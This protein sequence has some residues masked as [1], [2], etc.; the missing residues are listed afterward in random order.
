NEA[1]ES[2]ARTPEFLPVLTENG[3]VDSGGFGLTLL[4]VGFV[5]AF[6][7]SDNMLK[8]CESLVGASASVAIE[9]VNDWAGSKYKYCTE[10]LLHSETIKISYAK[11]YLSKNGDCEILV[12]SHPDFKVH[13]HTDNPGQILS[14]MTDK[15]E[16]SEVFVHNMKLESQER[17]DRLAEEESISGESKEADS[18]TAGDKVQSQ[19]RVF[20]GKRDDTADKR[21]RK[22][23]NSLLVNKAEALHEKIA[24]VAVAS[25]KG[26]VELLHTMGVDVVV[27]GGQTM[28]PSTSDLIAAANLTKAQSVIFLPSNKNIVMSA[29]TAADTLDIPA[30]VVPTKSVCATISAIFG[31][32]EGQ[33]LDANLQAMGECIENLVC[34]E[35]TRAIKKS[36]TALGE[37]IK[38]NDAIGLLN[39]SLDFVKRTVKEVLFSMLDEHAAGKDTL[40][41]IAGKD[42][43]EKDFKAICDEIEEKYPDLFVDAHRG[44]QPLYPLIFSLE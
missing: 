1:Y 38:K 42:L 19:K 24:L 33:D 29:N 5:S 21:S 16:I 23:K 20:F 4:I 27:S 18:I 15:G 40:T 17:A 41:L 25:G 11:K 32:D 30:K 44:F 2:C 3:V 26:I 39:G 10:F 9:Q 14:Y 13:V 34:G 31:F 22:S 35:I 28:N 8:Q 36:Q 37:S 12:G 7:G 43:K 6:S